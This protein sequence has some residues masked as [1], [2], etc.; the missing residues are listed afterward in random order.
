MH[1]FVKQIKILSII[2][3]TEFMNILTALLTVVDSYCVVSV[4]KDISSID[5]YTYIAT[6]FIRTYIGHI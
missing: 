1:E 6:S 5:S 4:I 3:R 2:H